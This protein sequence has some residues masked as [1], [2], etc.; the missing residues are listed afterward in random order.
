MSYIECKSHFGPRWT[1]NCVLK[2]T[3]TTRFGL[4]HFF[5]ET[6]RRQRWR[7]LS[8]ENGLKAVEQYV[9]EFL[10][11]PEVRWQSACASAACNV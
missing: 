4:K 6:S 3:P 10:K 5:E 1:Y 7:A 9:E 11:H 8:P 2:I